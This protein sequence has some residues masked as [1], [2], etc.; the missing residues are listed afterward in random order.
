M[1]VMNEQ[2]AKMPKDDSPPMD[3]VSVKSAQLTHLEMSDDRTATTYLS[4]R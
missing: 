3:E 2:F 1:S 4:K